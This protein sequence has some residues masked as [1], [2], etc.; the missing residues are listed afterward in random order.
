[1]PDQFQAVREQLDQH[2]GPASAEQIARLFKRAP[3]KK[4]AELLQTLATLGQ[5]RQDD[6]DRFSNAS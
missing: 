2:P 5:V 6:R 3:T 1:M 4:V